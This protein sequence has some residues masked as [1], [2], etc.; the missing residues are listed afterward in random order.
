MQMMFW[1]IGL[2][3]ILA[4]AAP[5]QAQMPG[6]LMDRPEACRL[7]EQVVRDTCEIDHVYACPGLAPD[8]SRVET[9][10]EGRLV[11]VALLEHGLLRRRVDGWGWR[12]EFEMTRGATR[13][14]I[15]GGPGAAED[16]DYTRRYVTAEG[17]E[18]MR[19]IQ[20]MRHDGFETLSL[21]SGPVEAVRFAVV[22]IQE[23]GT[24]FTSVRLVDPATGT[25]LAMTTT[26]QSAGAETRTSGWRAI[27]V[28]GP[29]RV[30]T[31]GCN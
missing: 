22:A 27:S 31:D 11:M 17:Q 3:A 24:R 30:T 28:L 14:L 18:I 15:E 10:R 26:E 20:S 23:D 4:L 12:I 2:M 29:S 25:M 8:E 6:D 7:L 5:V 16:I 9:W 21:D 19:G 13:R 1:R